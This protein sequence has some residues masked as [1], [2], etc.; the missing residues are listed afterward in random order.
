MTTWEARRQVVIGGQQF[1][2]TPFT[3]IA[4][5]TGELLFTGLLSVDSAGNPYIL[6]A[7]PRLS[8]RE[9]QRVIELYKQH[10]FTIGVASLERIIVRHLKNKKSPKVTIKW[11]ME[12][13][14]SPLKVRE[15]EE[16]VYIECL[17]VYCAIKEPKK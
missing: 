16:L 17:G 13:S 11:L 6:K 1:E 12:W 10:Q 9:R 4:D 8:H 15:G 2:V 7:E 3:C 5:A 14:T